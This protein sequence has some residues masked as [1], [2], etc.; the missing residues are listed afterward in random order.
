MKTKVNILIMATLIFIAAGCSVVRP[1]YNAMQWKPLSKGLDTNK[2]YS[3]GVV[4][5]WPWN[6]VVDYNMQWQT[7]DENVAILTE[8]ELHINMTVSVTIR[9]IAS[10]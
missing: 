2:I 10:E 9:P 6:G 5:N 4:W 7:Y 3:N 1:G 8:D